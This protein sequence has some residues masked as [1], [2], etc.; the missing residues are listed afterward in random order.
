MI[1]PY[2]LIHLLQITAQ[3]FRDKRL[4]LIDHITEKDDFESQ[5]DTSET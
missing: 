4:L 2:K 5:I 3:H 1:F